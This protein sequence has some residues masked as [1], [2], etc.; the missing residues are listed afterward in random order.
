M[1]CSVA[2]RKGGPEKTTVA[3]S[4]AFNLKEEAV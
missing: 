1:S 3:L 2:S 4:L